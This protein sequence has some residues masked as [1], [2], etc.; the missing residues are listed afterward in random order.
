MGPIE[1]T[2]KEIPKVDHEWRKSSLNDRSN[3][4]FVTGM[5]ARST[6][7]YSGPVQW[8]QPSTYDFESQELRG[9]IVR[10]SLCKIYSETHCEL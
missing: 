3:P 2:P 1:D 6:P 9:V 4:M 10:I 5:A 7:K 8:C